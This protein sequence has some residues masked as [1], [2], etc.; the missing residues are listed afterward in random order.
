M[1]LLCNTSFENFIENITH[2]LAKLNILY[3]KIFQAISLNNHFI[4]PEI[5]NKLLKFTDNAPW[6]DD[7]IDYITLWN[8]KIKENLILN[9]I[10]PINSGMISLVYKATDTENRNKII[11]IKRLHID[12]KLKNAIEN[13]L[14][15]V[16]ICKFSPFIQKYQISEVIHKN[17]DIIC[18]Q[19]NFSEEVANMEKMGINC[20]NLKYVVIPKC[21]KEITTKYPNV[22][23]M[24]Y[25]EGLPV[26]KIDPSDYDNY[27]KCILKFG[28]A[29]TLVHGFSHGDFHA[30]NILFIKDNETTK[31]KYKIG[32]LDYGIMYEINPTF[33]T[34][35][36]D[37][38]TDLFT[39][40]SKILASKILYS[41]F[42]EPIDVI[43]NLPEKHTDKLLNMMSIIIDD[44]IKQHKKANQ[45]LIYEFMKKFNDYLNENSLYEY[46]LH[47]SDD[48]IK[49]QLVLG[50]SHGVTLTL[51]KDNFMTL[52]NEVVNELFHINMLEFE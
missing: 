46:G 3:V 11:K 24:D 37:I 38:F 39:I 2:D 31:Y 36:M 41:G 32:V 23:V 18:H 25:I 17:I 22:I 35:L 34:I 19:T 5:S 10:T 14:F 13:L 16:R 33:R 49:T 26:S 27:A 4:T 52:S 6:S 44:V 9:S 51:C 48:F 45:S 15:L 42:I 28:F 20:K 7:D 47:P 21:D 8:L 50:M 1:Y 43:K 12:L 30:G 40:D 29:T